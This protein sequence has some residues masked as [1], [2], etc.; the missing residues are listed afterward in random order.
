MTKSVVMSMIVCALMSSVY[1]ANGVPN[2]YG[3]G[4]VRSIPNQNA[5]KEEVGEAK[6]TPKK[7]ESAAPM[8]LDADKAEYDQETGDFFA[9]GNVVLR[10]NGQVIRTDYAEGNMKTGQVF[11]KQGGELSENGVVMHADWAY[12]NF[13]SKTGELQ[14][15]SGTNYTKQE[16]YQAPDAVIKDG[17]MVAE[18]GATMSRC[19]SVKHPPCLSVVAKSF[20]VIPNDKMIAKDCWVKVRGVKIY[21]KDR[22]ENDLTNRHQSKYMPHI[23]YDSDKGIKL[24]LDIE[25]PLWEGGTA[26]AD[27]H[28]YGHDHWKPNFWIK[29]DFKDFVVGVS[30][31]WQEDDDDWYRK[32]T[33]WTFNWKRHRLIKGLP[34]TYS[35]YAEHGLWKRR[36]DDPQ[37]GQSRYSDRSW[38]TE[39]GGY[40][41]HDPIHFFGSKRNSLN[42]Y[43]GKKYTRESLTD[44]HTSSNL[45][46]ATL[47]QKIGSNLDV[48]IGFYDEK[49][50]DDRLFD[51]GQAD[52]S[53]EWRPG[54]RYITHNKRDE[55]TG[56]Y[57]LNAKQG[58][59]NN[60]EYGHRYEFDLTW[61]HHFCC[62]DLEFRYE[63]EF[64]KNDHKF[65]VHY[66]FNFF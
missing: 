58:V 1:A 16:W 36:Y 49:V 18:H 28:Y 56:V 61:T 50:S 15:V 52:M 44:E 37:P 63:K 41:Y 47:S 10:Q 17:K 14:K 64:Y 20:E 60:R 4:D 34:L 66:Y 23:G 22:W 29:Q 26:G 35:A 25:H 46:G 57:R 31:G 7:A 54:F 38:H 40:I 27:L 65:T 33:N 24:E 30:D 32:D 55:I 59:Y 62:W 21:H 48:W 13:L 5:A 8:K 6:I 51:I 42:L 11:L 12:Y 43:V 53:R 3:G 19:P 9:Q 45:Y 2:E 39:Y